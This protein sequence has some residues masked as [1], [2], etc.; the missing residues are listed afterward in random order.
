MTRYYD[1]AIGKMF[2]FDGALFVVLPFDWEEDAYFNM[3]VC[4]KNPDYKVG[5]K[6]KFF[7]DTLVVEMDEKALEKL[8]SL[9]DN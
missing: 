7:D 8:H 5:S 4:S 6:Y 1:V 3:C 2:K 9:L